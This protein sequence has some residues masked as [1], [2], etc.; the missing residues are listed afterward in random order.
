M[1]DIDQLRWSL[2]MLLKNLCLLCVLLM[3][4]SSYGFSPIMGNLK[5][6]QATC[7]GESF[8]WKKHDN[9]ILSGSYLVLGGKFEKDIPVQGEECRFE[10]RYV[11]S[12]AELEIQKDGSAIENA[13]LVAQKR[14]ITC[15][16]AG[17]SVEADIKTVE[18]E[19][20]LLKSKVVMEGRDFR[21]TI[22]E[23]ELCD[24]EVVIEA[25]HNIQ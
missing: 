14:V 1:I 25:A 9:I 20:P 22:E 21:I 6:N 4:V 24:G 18:I 5:V 16:Q 15:F 13:Q 12:E 19:S 3:T 8:L 10:D 23:R 2:I 17:N 11:R 7:G